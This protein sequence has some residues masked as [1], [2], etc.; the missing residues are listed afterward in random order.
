MNTQDILTAISNVGFPIVCT[1]MLGYAYVN[2]YNS[3]TNVLHD[4]QKTI[5]DNTKVLVELNTKL[6]D[7]KDNNN[8]A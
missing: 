8:H 5:D 2:F 1:I 6:N 7:V 4:L 3:T